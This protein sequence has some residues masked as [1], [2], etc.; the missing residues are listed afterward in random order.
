MKTN[1]EKGV[2]FFVATSDVRE[3]ESVSRIYMEVAGKECF[4]Y[5]RNAKV[6]LKSKSDYYEE[7]CLIECPIED[8]PNLYRAQLLLLH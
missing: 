4:I 6:W 1:V 7:V 3:Y 8:I 2:V 5:M